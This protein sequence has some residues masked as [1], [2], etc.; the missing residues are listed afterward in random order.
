M[1][2]LLSPLE[3]LLALQTLDPGRHNCIFFNE[4]RAGDP[5]RELPGPA[6]PV[7]GHVAKVTNKFY[8][9]C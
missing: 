6:P 1:A 7:P 8:L 3:I 2:N 4:N 5:D 9:Y